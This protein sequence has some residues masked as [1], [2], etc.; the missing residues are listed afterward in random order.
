MNDVIVQ[1][2]IL[3]G[4]YIGAACSPEELE[5]AER[6]K[7]YDSEELLN[8]FSAWATE[9]LKGDEEDTVDFFNVK[10]AHLLLEERG[11]GSVEENRGLFARKKLAEEILKRE[12]LDEYSIRSWK[13]ELIVCNTMLHLLIEDVQ[14][15]I[16]ERKNETSYGEPQAFLDLPNGRALEI[17]HEEEGL[18]EKDQYYSWRVHCSEAEFE[19]NCFC[20]AIG[21]ISQTT[22]KDIS[23]E[24]CANLLEWAYAIASETKID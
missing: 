6:M 13:D 24:T 2:A 21:I 12:D 14:N 10:L 11:I 4:E 23:E 15:Q 17:T 19:S 3:W 8:L 1:F 7:Q 20:D 18:E 16:S 22:S 9:Y 5:C